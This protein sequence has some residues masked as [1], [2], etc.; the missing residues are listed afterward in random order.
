M[1]LPNF[2]IEFMTGESVRF[3]TSH[4]YLAPIAGLQISVPTLIIGDLF[5]MR[6]NRSEWNTV[7]RDYIFKDSYSDYY[8]A[9]PV[10]VYQPFE[11]PID[12]EK[13]DPT[14][15]DLSSKVKRLITAL[16]LYKNGELLE[17]SYTVQFLLSDNVRH[18]VVGSYRTEYLTYPIDGMTYSLNEDEKKEVELI[19][20]TIG[21]IEKMEGTE[22][23]Q[24]IIDQFNLS[25]TPL[26]SPFFS[27]HILLTVIEMLFNVRQKITIH[28]N[29]YTRALAIFHWWSSGSLI[30]EFDD[31]Y[32]IHIRD[33]RNRIHHNTLGQSQIDLG[34]AV[35]FLQEP[36]RIGIRMFF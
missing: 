8:Q 33:L 4:Y 24:S 34:K 26:T 12:R 5:L 20:W 17:P 1:S 35:S 25:Y 3:K 23:L 22:F 21:L 31:F 15:N 2:T 6:C 13:I 29:S 11:T 28:S 7:E 9:N 30:P 16:R 27:V 32:K 19:Y 18:R 10:F 36:I 14:I